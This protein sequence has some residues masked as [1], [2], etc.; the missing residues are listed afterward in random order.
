MWTID[1][2]RK[3]V[4]TLWYNLDHVATYIQLKEILCKN[5]S[6]GQNIVTIHSI[7]CF[8]KKNL[9]VIKKYLKAKAFFGTER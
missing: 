3:R 7:R 5:L 9:T 2:P 6:I 1:Q 8:S 4:E